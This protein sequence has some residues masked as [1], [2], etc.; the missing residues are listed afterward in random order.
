MPRLSDPLELALI[1]SLNRAS[2]SLARTLPKFEPTNF[3]RWRDKTMSIL[4]SKQCLNVVLGTVD[5][6]PP[7]VLSAQR[8]TAWLLLLDSLERASKERLATKAM[9]EDPA[10]LWKRL[11]EI[12]SLAP[13][14]FSA[15][16]ATDTLKA[17]RQQRGQSSLLT[18]LQLFDAQ[19]DVAQD[20]LTAAGRSPL[21]DPSLIAYLRKGLDDSHQTLSL[22]LLTERNYHRFTHELS[23]RSFSAGLSSFAGST[24]ERQPA[25]RRGDA[26]GDGNRALAA[27]GSDFRCY[28]CGEEGHSRRDCPVPDIRTKICKNCGIAGHLKKACKGG[29]GG[30]IAKASTQGTGHGKGTRGGR[31]GNGAGQQAGAGASKPSTPRASKAEQAL[32]LLEAAKQERDKIQARADKRAQAYA[33]AARMAREL[34]D[35]THGQASR[36]N[37]DQAAFI[38]EPDDG[39]QQY[40]APTR[41]GGGA[42]KGSAK[43]ALTG[44]IRSVLLLSVCLSLF[45]PAQSLPTSSFVPALSDFSDPS[46]L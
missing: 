32:K 40:R 2:E 45:G 18:Y 29:P 35:D 41:G 33:A 25:Q 6:L 44:G 28:G 13:A 46:V 14:Y 17:L 7:N 37:D 8:N 23:T 3:I 15:D 27:T 36:N 21:D 24:R 4:R 30:G 22:S 38:E 39:E 16:D 5:A 19:V 26:G 31:T 43:F 11:H 34:D 10:L 42:R 9:N 20:A 12:Y 1:N